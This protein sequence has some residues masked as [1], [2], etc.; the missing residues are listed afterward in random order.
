[1]MNQGNWLIRANEVCIVDLDP[2]EF[3]MATVTNVIGDKVKVHVLDDP[4]DSVLAAGESVVRRGSKIW[5]EKEGDNC[6]AYGT[7][8]AQWATKAVFIP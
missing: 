5:I 3:A 8:S 6:V 1:M 4:N 2:G 7:F